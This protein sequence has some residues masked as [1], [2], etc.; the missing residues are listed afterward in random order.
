MIVA[1]LTGGLG[2]QLFQWA[3][4]YAAARRAGVGVAVDASGLY[5]DG[6]TPR[7]YALG[8]FGIRAEALAGERPAFN[9][10]EESGYRTVGKIAD[11]TRI[12]GMWTG[13]KPW[14]NFADE[15]RAKLLRGRLRLETGATAVHV[16]RTD[17]L[18]PRSPMVELGADY[19][20]AALAKIDSPG[21]V[22]VFSD[23]PEEA[24]QM[25]IGRV[26]DVED[27]WLAFW[28]MVSCRNHVIANS[29]FSWWAAW[30]GEKGTVVA[31][32][33]WLRAN[34]AV[35]KQIV[36]ERWITV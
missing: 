30:L 8:G 27:A 11:G 32:S 15:I 22:V 23:A 2:N 25:G 36:P 19:Y 21:E 18:G 4:A 5:D 35:T 16:R 28:L 1:E 14:S 12:R 7:S 20:R 34:T 13:E 17:F 9:V 33:R 24:A 29:S 26:I 3:F 10:I 31:P 6:Q